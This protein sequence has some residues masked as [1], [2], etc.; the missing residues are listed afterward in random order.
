MK[1]FLSQHKIAFDERNV[2]MDPAALDE[3]E[4]LGYATTPVTVIDGTP[5]IGFDPPRLKA[6]LGL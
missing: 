5:V 3:L 1:E 2:A 4:K 6:L